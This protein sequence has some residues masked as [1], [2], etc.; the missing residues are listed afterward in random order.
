MRDFD[1]GFTSRKDAIVLRI[2]IDFDIVNDY[3]CHLCRFRIGVDCKTIF[4]I[5]VIH[6]RTIVPIV[7]SLFQSGWDNRSARFFHKRLGQPLYSVS[8]ELRPMFCFRS[9]CRF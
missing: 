4:S 5:A 8:N 9:S 6:G 2:C 3:L 1:A 7:L